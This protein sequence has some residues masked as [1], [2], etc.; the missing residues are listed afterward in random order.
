MRAETNLW[1]FVPA[2]DFQ[3]PAPPAAEAARGGMRRLW[4]QL[5]G[6]F[7]GNASDEPESQRGKVQAPAE[8]LK[9]VAGNPDWTDAAANLTAHLRD[10]WLEQS[11]STQ[12]VLSVIGPPGCEIGRV[13]EIVADNLQL[14]LITEPSPDELLT[15]STASSPALSFCED[16]GEQVV[17]V[18][19]LERWFF[20]H[21][22]GL[23][24]IRQLVE[25]IQ[26]GPIRVLLGC[27]SWAWQYL[28]HSIGIED[29]LSSP[30]AL[31][32]FDASRLDR[33]LRSVLDLSE[34]QF[35]EGPDGK[36]VFPT[37]PAA[38]S[39]EADGTQRQTSSVV[40]V[41]AA[42]A[43]G[44]PAVAFAMFL[45][46]L[47]LGSG[48]PESMKGPATDSSTEL[49]V[50]SPFEHEVAKIAGGFDRIDRFLLHSLLL[51]RGVPPA[52][53]AALLPFSRT[54]IQSRIHRL[55]NTGTVE[56]IEGRLSVTLIAYPFVRKDLQS[57]GF[58]TDRF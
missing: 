39:Q 27:D 44:N 50:T 32:A 54:A 9:S 20:R 37:S 11:D 51:H 2:P 8:F 58:L 15:H 28:Q 12:K 19:R 21:A 49:W 55:I 7:I 14:K 33:W 38:G 57:D 34:I 13:L 29:I 36:A 1:D 24:L 23:S 16:A 42:L 41:L 10:G 56:L 45:A 17:V 18:P 6:V 26:N 4:E 46:G 53:L 30:L 22:E 48:E 3:L 52:L 47:R 43:R 35:R 40:K 25:R 31:A 5:A